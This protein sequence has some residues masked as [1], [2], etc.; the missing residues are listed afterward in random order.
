LQDD[1]G[2]VVGLADLEAESGCAVRISE[3]RHLCSRS[4][5]ATA[6]PMRASEILFAGNGAVSDDNARVTLG[7]PTLHGSRGTA[8]VERPPGR[9]HRS[10]RNGASCWPQSPGGPRLP[11]PPDSCRTW[12]AVGG[13][14]VELARSRSDA[15][16]PLT[17][18]AL[19]EPSGIRGTGFRNVHRGVDQE[20]FAVRG[21]LAG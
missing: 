5:E 12:S 10:C 17:R 7:A 4:P 8:R 16:A 14:R 11:R 3:R 21:R 2:D 1:P 19:A 13:S 18:R 9:C 15:S 20:P 6:S